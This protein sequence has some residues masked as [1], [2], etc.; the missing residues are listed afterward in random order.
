MSDTS[1]GSSFGGGGDATGPGA[2][3]DVPLDP[4]VS[5]PAASPMAADASPVQPQAPGIFGSGFHLGPQYRAPD[6]TAS[7]LDQTADVLQQR[8][9]RANEV[10]SN[11]VLQFFNPEGVAAARQFVP[12]AT[13]ELQKIR[14]QQADM[15]ANRIQAHT[16]GLNPGEVPDEASMADRVEVARA[17]ALKGDLKVFK[18]LQAVDPKTAEAIQDQVHEA[19]AGHLTKAQLAFD[20]LSYTQNQGQ[21]AAKLDQLRKEGTLTD[22]EAL[23]LKVPSSFD[24]FNAA[25]ASEGKALRD[26]RIG[27]DSI[28][29]KLEDRNTYQPMEK[30]E[31]ETY[32]GRLKTAYGDDLNGV[33]GRN[34][35][36]N[37]R[38]L[39]VNGMDD[40]RNLGKTFT[41]ASEDQR[42]AIG[43][44]GKNAVPKEDLEKARSFTRT[45]EL[46]TKDAKGN[47]LPDGKLNTNPNVQQGVAEGLAS[48]LRGGNGGANVGLL[49]IELA[50]R[51]WAQGAIDGLVSNYAG[52][53]NTLF[54]DANRTDKPY[55]SQAT[56]KQIRDVMDVLQQYNKE[57]ISGRMDRI[58]ERAGALGLDSSVFGYKKGEVPAIDEA[59]ERGNKAQVDRMMPM[60]Q[61]IGGGDGVL[62]LGAQRPGTAATGLPPGSQPT[63]Q[64]PGATPLQ[65]PVQQ[66][67]NPSGPSPAAPQPTAPGGTPPGS[68]QPSAS[69]FNPGG[70]APPNG[71]GPVPIA[72]QTINVSLPGGA[73]PNFVPALQRI[74]SGG[75]RDPWRAGAKGSSAS[76]AFQF[77]NST[78]ADNKPAGAPARAAD[79]TPQ[80]Q[81]E[82]LAT[83]TAKNAASL[84]GAGLPVNDTTLYVA[85]NL[86]S[87]GAASLLSAPPTADAR[88]I[89]GEA[90]ARNNPMFFKGRPTV[91]TVLQ[92]YADAMNGAGTDDTGP[93]PR[94][95]S[96]GATAEAPTV[97]DRVRNWLRVPDYAV[98]K[99]GLESMTPE[100]M[101][102]VEN[103]ARENLPTI[104]SIAGAAL[105]SI[106][107]PGV[108]TAVGGGV[109]GAAGQSLKDYLAGRNQNPAKIAEEGALGAL[110]GVN[111]ANRLAGAAIRT[112]GAGAIT[113]AGKLAEGG[114]AEQATETGVSNAATALGG[115]AFGRALGMVG[116]KVWNLFSPEAKQS[117]QTAAQ[118]YN[119]AAKALETEQPK[120]AG[121]DGASTPNP[122]YDAAVAAKEQAE[123]TL[124]DAGLNPEEAAYAAR[125]AGAGTREAQVMKPA[126]AE[127]G[128]IGKGYARLESE[129][130][131]KGVGAPKATP[132]LPD[133]PM[134]AVENKQ[135]SSK[136]AELAE[137]T[138]AAIT[139]PAKS[140]QD[141][142]T[143]LKDARSQLLTAERDALSS[144]E[145]GRSKTA[146]DMRKLAD[147]V[148]V[149]QEKVAKHVFGEKEGAEFMQRLK[150]LDVRYRNLMEATNGMD[151]QKMAST[152][153]KNTE[154]SRDM[155]RK[156][157]AAFAHDP[158]ALRAWDSLRKYRD[159]EATVP[160]TVA[161][162]GLPVVGKGV[163]ALKLFGLLRDAIREQAA[164]NPVRF[165]DL[166]KAQP[167]IIGPAA[168]TV[169]RNAVQRG[170]I[171]SQ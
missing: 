171:M 123:R 121:A 73:S 103:N 87:G 110:F 48:M 2:S 32:N 154:A 11:P 83:L 85:H 71:G 125:V 135:V 38:A 6:P 60:H 9:K 44:A 139:A 104:G 30:K 163:K 64:L 148:R 86:G 18:G 144:T 126:A 16:L 129:I 95:G 69:S 97:M 115:E 90:A 89:V 14:Q 160:W 167:D 77:I 74:E 75:E 93:K 96:G 113:A 91:A 27:V 106:V 114:T 149:Q 46:A 119:E 52:A 131:A 88:S 107:S 39:V 146:A 23:G 80:Q 142:W 82:A 55:L 137:R 78:W 70:G 169:G 47:A 166:V 145:A 65:T 5:P 1:F 94:P 57:S 54:S 157:K 25:K 152:M 49:K 100:E 134:A 128:D 31:A 58:A 22:L 79:A 43:E 138:E 111:P 68:T 84:K 108:G 101:A 117:V 28:R 99:G 161:A 118:K 61:A 37:A 109:G 10:A 34:A 156:F 42:K 33:W 102:Q 13:E 165:R 15:Q 143:Q 21:Y 50:K 127:A 36:S 153:Q 132:K 24:A 62:Q 20:S 141:K 4:R 53:M 19:V 168:E 164:G 59:V 12:K 150:V 51:G 133:G 136:H 116:H 130:G 147:T 26:A 155:D 98:P 124:K 120:L 81:A 105:G 56:Q 92:R 3:A 140:W 40:P 63:T 112:G 158:D 122:K 151:F 45:Y 35:G 8:V 162:E 76:G 41:L 7:P 66:S 72:G 29:Q 159:P 170:A 67:Q 17:R